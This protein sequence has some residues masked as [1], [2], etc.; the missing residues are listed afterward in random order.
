MLGDGLLCSAGAMFATCL[1]MA[2]FGHQASCFPVGREE[3]D[4]RE[5]RIC[6]LTIICLCSVGAEFATKVFR[7]LH[8]LCSN[9]RCRPV[10]IQIGAAVCDF[11]LSY[12]SLI[13]E[14]LAYRECQAS[15]SLLPIGL[16]QTGGLH[17]SLPRSLTTTARA[18]RQMEGVGALGRCSL[19]LSRDRT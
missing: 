14:A 15:S 7:R 16:Q 1:E 2:S 5:P 10:G 3:D 13:V 6:Q 4:V 12:L 18:S 8:F 17:F 19:H 11:L 9:M